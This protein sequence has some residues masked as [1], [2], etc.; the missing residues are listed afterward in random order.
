[1]FDDAAETNPTFFRE[2]RASSGAVGR[3]GC[4]LVTAVFSVLWLVLGWCWAGDGLVL[5]G[6]LA[7]ALLGRIQYI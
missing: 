2:G 6:C 1:M 3:A 7:G 4:Q 5:G